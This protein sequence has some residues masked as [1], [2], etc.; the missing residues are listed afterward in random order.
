MGGG[1]P[2]LLSDRLVTV[3]PAGTQDRGCLGLTHR[4]SPGV[5]FNEVV[6]KDAVCC[7]ESHYRSGDS[8]QPDF[9]WLSPEFLLFQGDWTPQLVPAHPLAILLS[10]P[11]PAPPVAPRG[12]GRTEWSLAP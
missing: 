1:N 2:A 8:L 7:G 3:Q 9:P 11:L 4:T 10:V 12:A 5:H 6:I